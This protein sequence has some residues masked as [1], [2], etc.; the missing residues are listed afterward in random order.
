MSTLATPIAMGWPSAPGA[1]TASAKRMTSAFMDCAVIG[2]S[3]RRE[4]KREVGLKV[5]RQIGPIFAFYFFR[6]RSTLFAVK[7]KRRKFL[8]A[9]AVLAGAG[10]VGTWWAS[11]SQRRSARWLRTIVAD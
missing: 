11:T 2:R 6:L 10:A 8:R 5:R 1:A 4:E 7:Q 9:M 3:K